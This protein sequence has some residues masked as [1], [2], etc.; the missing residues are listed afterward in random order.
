M[1]QE[2]TADLCVIGAGSAGLSVAAGAAQ[3]GADVVLIERGAMGG[4]CLNTG[5]V[6]SKSLIAAAAATHAARTA[7]R[8][9]VRVGEPR[10][11]FAAVSR[12]V[13]GVI[14]SIA[15]HDSAERF[16]RLGVT[17][18]REHARFVGPDRLEAGAHLIQARRFV[19]AT[20]SRPAVPPLPGLQALPYL[21]NE[22]IFGLS[23]LPRRLLVL[24][25][26]PIGC[27]LAQAFRRLGA[28]VDLVDLGPILPREDPELTAVVRARMLDEGVR[29]HEHGTA[30]RAEPGPRLVL[31]GAT[32]PM[33]GTHLLV[34][35][36]RKATVDGLDLDAAGVSYD[37]NGIK[38]DG[39]LRTTNAR[40]F[41]LGD[42]IGGP[43]FTHAA[44]YQAG[45]VIRNALF[46]LPARA[47]T[48]AMPRVTFTD[49]E[50]AAV[51]ISETEARAQGLTV[52]IV[53]SP[54]TENDRA[55]TERDDEGLV[56]AVVGRGG[57]VL[58]AAI[59]G[60]HASEL[61]LPWVLA[62]ERRMR[63]SAIAGLIVPYPTRSEASKRAAG[64]YY[65]PRLFSW[66]TRWLVRQLA[67]FG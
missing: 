8:F 21:T 12:H 31:E 41:A 33:P 20:G 42:V 66:R 19:I 46:R 55:R 6:P 43:Q 1:R 2:R 3:L 56:K 11:D 9:G 15:P 53:R 27:E 13:R 25:A 65:A 44:G 52:E 28:E 60:A 61:I 54:F 35:T 40:V 59:A 51:G 34:A 49:P 4:D 47:N 16:E 38:V 5:C 23:E 67:R 29:L 14:D 22:S 32:S 48:R 37:P 30:M 39:R 62:V 58:G 50:I 7:E 57:R 36:G 10:V 45:I 17:V 64:A 24:G 26:G 63:L 18:L